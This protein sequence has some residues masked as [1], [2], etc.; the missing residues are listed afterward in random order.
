M[1]DIKEKLHGRVIYKFK[2][3]HNIGEFF[4]SDRPRNNILT[5]Y[6]TY[7]KKHNILCS[8]TSYEDGTTIIT[9]IA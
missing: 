1:A 3:L 4:V 5:S 9:R 6:R 2:H 7:K 8:F